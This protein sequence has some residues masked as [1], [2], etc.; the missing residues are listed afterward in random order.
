MLKTISTDVAQDSDK[1]SSPR[2]TRCFVFPSAR[3]VSDIPHITLRSWCG[4]H[5]STQKI[6]IRVRYHMLRPF[7]MRYCLLE[8]ANKACFFLFGWV[9]APGSGEI[10]SA[11]CLLYFPAIPT[12]DFVFRKTAGRISSSRAWIP[13]LLGKD[14]NTRG[15]LHHRRGKNHRGNPWRV[16]RVNAGGGGRGQPLHVLGDARRRRGVEAAASCDAGADI[17]CS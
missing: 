3:E 2:C 5:T 15:R 9:F 16:R 1:K 6:L 14:H 13:P 17:V 4:L 11:L 7:C 12:A 10:G 8:V